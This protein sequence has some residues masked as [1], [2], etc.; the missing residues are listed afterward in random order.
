LQHDPR[1]FPDPERFDPERWTEEARRSRPEFSY[2]PFGGGKRRCIGEGFA[3]AEGVMILVTLA[4]WW[5][6]SPASPSPVGML[7]GLVLR[8]EAKLRLRVERRERG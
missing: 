5:R 2:F 4:Q 3:W 6:V 7:A 1:F 8:P